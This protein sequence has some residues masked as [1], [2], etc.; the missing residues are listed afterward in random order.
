MSGECCDVLCN[1]MQSLY[2]YFLVLP[3]VNNLRKQEK[4]NIFL[5]EHLPLL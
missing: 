1:A 5:N 3:V 4:K 2:F